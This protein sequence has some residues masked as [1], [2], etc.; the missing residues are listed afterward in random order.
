MSERIFQT[1]W[2]S[3]A[4]PLMSIAHCHFNLKCIHFEFILNPFLPSPP[5]NPCTYSWSL[6]NT[7]QPL[8]TAA[9]HLPPLLLCC[10][11]PHL[12][13]PQPWSSSHKY[14]P[15]CSAKWPSRAFGK[16]PPLVVHKHR[17]VRFSSDTWPL[18]RHHRNSRPW[19]SPPPHALSPWLWIESCPCY[20]CSTRRPASTGL[21]HPSAGECGNLGPKTCRRQHAIPTCCSRRSHRVGCRYAGPWCAS[22]SSPAGCCCWTCSGRGRTKVELLIQRDY[23]WREIIHGN[24]D[25]Y[26]GGAASA[27]GF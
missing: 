2:S 13:R 8:A 23:K 3:S 16:A 21:S 9:L 18:A 15:R 22:P 4:N 10:R 5:W 19:A 24:L 12:F 26:S 27:E 25:S 17:P 6:Q 11:C 1:Q 7:F 20:T 14:S